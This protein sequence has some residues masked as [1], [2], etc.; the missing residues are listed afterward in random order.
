MTAFA[1]SAIG[2][3]RIALWQVVRACVADFRLTGAPSPCLEVDLSDGQRRGYLVLRPP[4][5]NDLIVAPTREI[6]GI[7]D[8]HLQS[9]GAPNYF[10]AAWRARSFLKGADGL[11][12]RDK[13]Q[14]SPTP[15]SYGARTSTHPRGLSPIPCQ[16][17]ARGGCT[18]R[19][20]WQMGTNRA[21]VPHTM[22][23]GMRIAE[24]IFRAS[25]RSGLPWT[26]LQARPYPRG[27]DDRGRRRA[28]RRRRSIPDSRFLR[29]G[30][31]RA[32][33]CSRAACSIGTARPGSRPSD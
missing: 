3:G 33:T 18:E 10:D 17:R 31:G 21:V 25:R 24:R 20:D 11:P 7:E 16:T 30:N 32:E 29:R 12:E 19:P 2:L 27:P 23:W 4:L 9:T 15:P 13:M 26:P 1:I 6:V 5:L 8:L 28:G 22:F 14:S